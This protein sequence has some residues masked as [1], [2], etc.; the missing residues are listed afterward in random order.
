MVPTRPK[1]RSTQFRESFSIM[2]PRPS[3]VRNDM[4]ITRHVHGGGVYDP[5]WYTTHLGMWIYL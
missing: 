2:G 4:D 3:R 1:S 5:H